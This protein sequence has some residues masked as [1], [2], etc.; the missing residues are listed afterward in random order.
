MTIFA[1][2]VLLVSAAF[3][4]VVWP[5]FWKR[6]ADDPRATD[7]ATGK[8]T[9]FYTVHAVL[10]SIALLIGVCALGAGLALL[11]G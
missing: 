9:R 11:I 8:R 5:R 1:A 10:I 6:V 7:Q 4:I 2:I 3:N